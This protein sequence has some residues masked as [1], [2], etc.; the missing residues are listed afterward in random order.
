MSIS[1]LRAFLVAVATVLSALGSA[2]AATVLE[3]GKTEVSLFTF[4]SCDRI[5]C[6]LGD[7]TKTII[8]PEELQIF[9]ISSRVTG[10]NNAHVWIDY[11]DPTGATETLPFLD[12]SDSSAPLQAGTYDFTIL[13]SHG[14]WGETEAQ[15]KFTI[16]AGP[17]SAAGL[18]SV[19]V[20]APF[21][22]LGGALLALAGRRAITPEGASAPAL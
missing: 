18:S 8:V 13:A 5:Y 2:Q 20:P 10:S 9:S 12:F 7:Q 19:P 3:A 16:L 22:L 6:Y 15:A 21:V 11:T 17:V 14:T 1:T 4:A